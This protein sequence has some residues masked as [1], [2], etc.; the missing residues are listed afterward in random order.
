MSD[1]KRQSPINVHA[2]K[3]Y[4]LGRLKEIVVKK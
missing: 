3:K 4:M 2:L 1:N